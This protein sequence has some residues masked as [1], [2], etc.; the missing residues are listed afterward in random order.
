MFVPGFCWA[1]IL[2][3]LV[4]SN[5]VVMLDGVVGLYCWK[6]VVIEVKKFWVRRELDIGV[7]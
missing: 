1:D 7:R 6:V 2:E 5:L 3:I 4:W